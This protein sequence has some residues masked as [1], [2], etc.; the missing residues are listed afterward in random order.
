MEILSRRPILLALVLIGICVATYVLGLFY[1]QFI[2]NPLDF[3]ALL[4]I[5]AIY[6]GAVY[7]QVRGFEK[8]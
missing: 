5:I 4:F 2:N 1:H 6:I 8:K 7:H 3:G